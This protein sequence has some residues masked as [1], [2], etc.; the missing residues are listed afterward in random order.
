MADGRIKRSQAQE[1]R[2]ARRFNG[3]RQPASG[4]FDTAKNDVK[5]DRYLIEN[6]RTDNNE[7][8]TLKVRDVRALG[9]NAAL[10]GRQPLMHVEIA[11]LHLVV[12][13]E[14]VWENRGTEPA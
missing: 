13:E 12:C 8:I 7:S 9:Q 6:K 2:T 3:R 14:W 11:G 1:R 10:I 5:S 4:A